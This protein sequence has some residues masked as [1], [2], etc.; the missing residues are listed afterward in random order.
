MSEKSVEPRKE[1]DSHEEH[2]VEPQRLPYE[3]PELKELGTVT[4]MTQSNVS[5]VW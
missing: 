1:Q 3:P 2:P 5:V 4:E